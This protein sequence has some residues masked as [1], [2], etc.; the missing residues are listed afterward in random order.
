MSLF[1]LT[2]VEVSAPGVLKAGKYTTSITEAKVEAMQSGKGTKLAVTIK[3]IDG[4]YKGRQIYH[5][6]TMKHEN[7]TAQKIGQQQLKS[8]MIC[9]G[10]GSVLDTASQLCGKA[11]TTVTKV[12]VDQT[13]VE[14]SR[15]KYFEPSTFVEQDTDSIPF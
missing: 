6:F 8:L 7:E 12:E 13:G 11:F 4:E 14:R 15:V 3:V 2:N 1:D 10:L 9:L 5:N